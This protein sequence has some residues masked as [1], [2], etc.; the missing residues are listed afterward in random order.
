MQT[1]DKRQNKANEKKGVKTNNEV[2]TKQME[3]RLN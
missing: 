1:N 3:K 2:K